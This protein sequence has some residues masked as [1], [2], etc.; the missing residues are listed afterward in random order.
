[1]QGRY[2]VEAAIGEGAFGI[3]YKGKDQILGISVAIKEYFPSN[4]AKR[5]HSHSNAVTV[6]GSSHQTVFDRDMQRFL[7]EAQ[8]LAKLRGEPG[9]VSV[10][11]FFNENGTAYIVMDYLNGI[12]LSAY[13]RRFG[14]FDPETLASIL[15][16]VLDAL[17]KVHAED[18]IHG[19][20]SPDNIM[21]LRGGRLKLLDFGAARKI[22]EENRLS[23]VLKPGY[24]PVEQYQAQGKLGPWTDVYALCATLYK[25]IT[26][27]TPEES[28]ERTLKDTV[29]PP[30]ELG[31]AVPVKF[32]QALMRGMCVQSEHR[33]QT[34]EAL[35]KSICEKSPENTGSI[36]IRRICLPEEEPAYS[37]D[38]FAAGEQDE[39]KTEVREVDVLDIF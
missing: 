20:I 9:V 15:S 31:V 28:T 30:S 8:V 3:T 21:M 35:R 19:D 14:P 29:L 25:C 27:I 16:P 4:C 5:D 12:T 13:L 36:Q 7:Q 37:G 33:C 38:D 6:T 23:V 2:A 11:N 10:Q 22:T 18:M 34:L 26:G 32:E 39:I 1:M 24:A 17:S